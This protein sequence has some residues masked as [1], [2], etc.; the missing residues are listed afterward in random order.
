MT[1]TG[2]EE[3]WL[4]ALGKVLH[5]REGQLANLRRLV[6]LGVVGLLAL[7]VADVLGLFSGS[8]SDSQA[9]GITPGGTQPRAVE[10]ASAQTEGALQALEATMAG[11]LAKVLSQVEGAGRVTVWLSLEVGPSQSVA[12]NR[13]T[14]SRKVTEREAS[15][16]T[17]ETSDTSEIAQPVLARADDRPI[18]LKTAAPRVGGVLVVAEGARY[19]EVRGRLLHAVE[20]ALG[21]PANRIQILP[22]EGR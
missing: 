19:A 15:G 12:E 7:L 8:R 21:V 10:P 1:N 3:Q 4:V 14:T 9:R 6:I 5:L 2:K 11:N 18:V 16:I 13:T 22:L 17:R 20:G